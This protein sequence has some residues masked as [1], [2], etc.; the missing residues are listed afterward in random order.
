MVKLS[1]KA[2]IGQIRLH[3]RLI[4]WLVGWLTP[5][6]FAVRRLKLCALYV[7]VLFVCLFLFA[8]SC[9]VSALHVALQDLFAYSHVCVACDAYQSVKI[10]MRSERI[11]MRIS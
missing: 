9:H 8:Y 5:Q 4:D 3:A 2:F 6:T 11:V 10:M 1:K 7:V